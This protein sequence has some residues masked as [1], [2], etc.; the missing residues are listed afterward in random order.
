MTSDGWHRYPEC[1]ADQPDTPIGDEIEG[2]LL[3][4][5][6]GTTGRPKGIKR[7]LA[8]C[9]ARRSARHDVGVGR[10]P[11]G[12]R[13]RLSE[14]RTAVS[15]R[16]VGVVD[17]DSGGG[18]HDRRDGQVRR[19]R[20]PRRDPALPGHHGQFVP[21]MFTRMLK[22]PEAVRD[23]YDVSSLQRVVHAAAPCPVDIKKQ[24]IDWWGPI[25][26]EYY[27]SSEATGR[28]IQLPA[29]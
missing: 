7:D 9:P 29:P 4:Y 11:D 15:H 19:R 23:S 5:S 20:L 8:A 26:D 25:V 1:V 18:H 12:P 6:S 17:D 14:P 3:Q 13:R 16:P 22:L 21:A 27:A 2:D 10:L 24:M 28:F